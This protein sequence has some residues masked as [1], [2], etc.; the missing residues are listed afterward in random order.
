MLMIIIIKLI[1][2]GNS[3]KIVDIIM[4]MMGKEDKVN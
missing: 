3:N 1:T 2:F 4:N